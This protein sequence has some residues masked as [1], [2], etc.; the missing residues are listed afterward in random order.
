MMMMRRTT[1][2]LV[3]ALFLFFGV[4]A[5]NAQSPDPA[6]KPPVLRSGSTYSKADDQSNSSNRQ[7]DRTSSTRVSPTLV[8]IP[9]IVMDRNGRYIANLHKEDFHIYEDGV[10]Q[11]LAYFASV[12]KPFTV[13]LML[14]VSGSTQYEMAQIRE[15]ADTFVSRLRFNDR[16]MAITFDGKIN[17]LADVADVRSIRQSKLHIPA[18]TDG[19]VLY[20][21]VEFALKRMAGFSGSKAIVLMTDGVDQSSVTEIGRASCRGRV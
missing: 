17:L 4:K 6:R 3:I 8:T 19:T 10:E 15:A 21:A 12:E 9:A 16:M 7:T 2:S 13:A 14:D 5:L 20:D 11:N 18:V 1:A